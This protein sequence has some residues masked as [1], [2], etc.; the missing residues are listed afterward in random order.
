M[1]AKGWHFGG[2]IIFL[3]LS[4]LLFLGF[5]PSLMAQTK[6][7]AVKSFIPDLVLCG[8]KHNSL[9]HVRKGKMD[10]DDPFDGP[11]KDVQPQPQAGTYLVTGG[12][13]QVSLIRKI[14]KGCKTIWDWSDLEGI[15]VESAVVADWDEKDNPTLILAADS[16]N[17]RLFLADAKSKDP[18]IR[19]DFKLPAPPR[20]VH[21][22][23]NSGNFLVTLKD[24]TVEEVFFQEDKVVW[25]LGAADGLKD[26][27]DAVR[28][29]WANTY[30]AD[31]AQG[32]ILS[33]GPKKQ[34]NWKTH[35]PFA[36]G[37]F[38]EMSL[39]L[40]RKSGKR[41]LLAAVHFSGEGPTAQNVVYVLSTETGNVLAWNDHDEKGGYPA[42]FKA[43][44]D[45]VEYYK[46]Q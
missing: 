35:L 7:P 22:C 34:L 20:R 45:R 33:F 12:S 31:A 14:W 17:Q 36:P 23:T 13:Q 39:A 6:A 15:A 4:F 10:W 27:R 8:K 32:D 46:K 18:Q 43:V 9:F 44:P 26:A 2:G 3:F 1:K 29:P 42:F 41:L 5:P 21:L 30:V 19:W 37:R 24:S 11:L 40:F 28:D 25:T 38:E 16:L